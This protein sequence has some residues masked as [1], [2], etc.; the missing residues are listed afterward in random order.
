MQAS[1][2]RSGCTFFQDPAPLPVLVYDVV[3]VVLAGVTDVPRQILV[4][5]VG[6]LPR[7]DSVGES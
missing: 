5:G 1:N 7:H 6:E 3:E 2:L 4:T